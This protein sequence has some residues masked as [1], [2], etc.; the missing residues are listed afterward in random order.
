MKLSSNDNPIEIVVYGMTLDKDGII[1]DT[2]SKPINSMISSLIS[3]L[4]INDC[5]LRSNKIL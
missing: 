4:K 1:K 2:Q 5:T 3:D